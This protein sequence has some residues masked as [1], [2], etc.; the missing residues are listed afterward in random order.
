MTNPSGGSLSWEAEI[1]ADEADRFIAWHSAA[2][3][4]S[5]W[6]ASVHLSAA[7]AGR[8]TEVRLMLTYLPPADRLNAGAINASSSQA[9]RHVREGL[10]RFK[11]RME[12][13]EVPH[14]ALSS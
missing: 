5:Y 14:A 13:R 11:Q 2:D 3:S 12:A 6:A 1:V 10:R 9:A 7:P 8:G 4:D